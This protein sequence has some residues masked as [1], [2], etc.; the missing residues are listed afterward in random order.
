LDVPINVPLRMA[1]VF[2]VKV[3]DAYLAVAAFTVAKHPGINGN[4][5]CI[6]GAN[7]SQAR[8]L[9]SAGAPAMIVYH[10]PRPGCVHW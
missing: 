2:A 6:D 3:S 4:A 1:D 7:A 8:W 9:L 5:T 10:S